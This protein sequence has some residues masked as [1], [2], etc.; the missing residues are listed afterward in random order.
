MVRVAVV[1]LGWAAR[2]IWLP[3]L[4]AHPS[5]RVCAVVDPAPAARAAVPL[6]G[7]ETQVLA[8]LDELPADR[9]DLAVVAVPNHLHTPVACRLLEQGVS[10]FVE[11]PVCLSA[12][13]AE[14]LADAEWAGSGVLLAGS[15]ARYRADVRELY[16]VAEKIGQ[17]RHLE[18][19]WVRARGVPDAGG[20]FTRR[21]LSGGGALVDLGWH[22]LDVA[23]PLLGTFTPVQVVGTTSGDFVDSGGAG[24]SWRHPERALTPAYQ[25][26]DVED[27]A[28]GFVVTDRGVSLSLR[29]SWASHEPCD[30]TRI[31]VDGT[32]GA[33]FLRCTF[34]FSP[35]RADGPSLRLVRN[36]EQVAVP[37]PDE[38]IG[39]EYDRQ[40]DAL[41]AMVLDGRR[42][43]G[44]AAIEAARTISIIE[45][46]YE[47]AHRP[48]AGP[49]HLLSTVSPR[50][51]P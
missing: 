9:V 37:L 46:L 27:T 18:V 11:K 49:A 34:G 21:E 24:A 33:A 32:D 38:P 6:A 19:A 36:G 12:A 31:R 30:V 44:H 28:R 7:T 16:A 48:A 47:S 3:R 1:G 8:G 2:S 45:R 10:V 42:A 26:G 20:W 51:Q 40:L 50:E 13:E 4:Q 15:A 29:A 43:K 17:I 5:F 22:L 41:S 39:A 14:R 25:T 35:N 23:S